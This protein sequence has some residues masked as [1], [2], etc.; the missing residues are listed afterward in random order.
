MALSLENNYK[1]A[2][3][4]AFQESWLFE[5]RNNTYTN[6]SV[7]TQYIRLGTEEVGSGD[8]KYNS[9]I[10]NNVHFLFCLLL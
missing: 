4:T 3:G 2:V 9:F 10:I 5:L 6:G 1:A 7:D 8:T